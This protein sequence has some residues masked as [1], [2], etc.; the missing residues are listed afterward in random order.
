MGWGGGWGG[1]KW[2]GEQC[3]GVL[4][5]ERTGMFLEVSLFPNLMRASVV[6]WK[7]LEGLVKDGLPRSQ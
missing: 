1:E 7:L 2:A 4:V 3:R 6:G 5:K